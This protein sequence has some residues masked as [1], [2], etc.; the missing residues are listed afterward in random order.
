MVKKILLGLIVSYSLLCAGIIYEP[1]IVTNDKNNLFIFGSASCSYCE[2]L[3]KDIENDAALKEALG[4]FNVYYIS[5]DS[6]IEYTYIDA[7]GVVKPTSNI[8]LKA[9]FGA[10]ATPTIVFFDPTWRKVLQLPGYVDKNSMTKLS[11]YVGKGLYKTKELQ[12]YI[13]ENNL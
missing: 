9:E 8:T 1:K 6:N 3:K 2:I 13:K 12:E 5:I 4:V 7:K 11:E 10:R